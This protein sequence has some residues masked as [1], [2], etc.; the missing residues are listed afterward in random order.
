MHLPYLNV[1][2][3]TSLNAKLDSATV[4]EPGLNLTLLLHWQRGGFFPVDGLGIVFVKHAPT[5]GF[6][7]EFYT[8]INQIRLL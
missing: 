4:Y 1:L 6:Y 7:H 3:S 8:K 2:L 5:E